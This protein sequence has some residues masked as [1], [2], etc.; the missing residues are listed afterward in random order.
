MVGAEASKRE[1]ERERERERKREAEREEK[2]EWWSDG[3]TRVQ[4]KQE[5]EKKRQQQREAMGASIKQLLLIA[6][7]IHIMP[8]ISPISLSAFRASG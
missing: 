1:R 5:R 2:R 4:S 8:V 7:S 3:G 6:L